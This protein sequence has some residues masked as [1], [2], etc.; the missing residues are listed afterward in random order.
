[1]LSCPLV[2]GPSGHSVSGPSRAPRFKCERIDDER[3]ALSEEED[4]E[5]ED[6]LPPGGQLPAARADLRQVPPLQPAQAAPPGLR[7]LRLVQGPR[8]RRGRLTASPAR[9]R[10]MTSFCTALRAAV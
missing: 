7:E 4:V 8:G 10:W 5:V 9:C 1:M 6:T 2:G 3:R